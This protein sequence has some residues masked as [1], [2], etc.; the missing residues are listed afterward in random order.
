E[1]ARA[2]GK[3]GVQSLIIESVLPE[4]EADANE[5]LQRMTDGRLH[6]GFQTQ[7]ET[8]QGRVVE[9]LQVLVGDELGT[10]SY[11]LF[12]G[13]ESFRVNFAIRI[14][15]ARLLARRA[16]A[17]LETLFIDEGFGTQDASGRDRLVEAIQAIQQDFAKILVVT[18]IEELKEAFPTRIEVTK[19]AEG[20]R[21]TL[22]YR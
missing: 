3:G 19:G 5:L 10:R 14:A 13:G 9:T 4:I 7:R 6:V 22:S 18:H 17:R 11:E 8:Q 20:S 2:F 1:L 12:S 16:G 21:F 15:L